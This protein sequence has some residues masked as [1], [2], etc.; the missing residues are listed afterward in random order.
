MT[1]DE[2]SQ[3]SAL[4]REIDRDVERLHELQSALSGH[5]SSI[6][7]LPHMGIL[8]D[9]VS[10]YL[11]IIDELKHQII[12]RVLDSIEQ[13]AKL[14]A[15]VNSID[16]PLI[17]QI[18]LYRYIDKLQWRQIVARI[19]GNNSEEALRAALTRYLLRTEK[20]Q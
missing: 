18:I 16:D 17:R 15:F 3:L 9:N 12:E 19:G 4:N 13:Y 20:N 6:S 7:G 11:S 5:T 10:L 8:K 2:L 14:N 1:H